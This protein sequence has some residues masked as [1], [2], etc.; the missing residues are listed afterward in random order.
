MNLKPACTLGLMLSTLLSGCSFRI[1]D[2]KAQ[3]LYPQLRAETNTQQQVPLHYVR[4]GDTTRPLLVYIHGS[5]GSWKDALHYMQ[6]ASLAEAFEL[7]AIDRPGFGYSGRWR[8]GYTL[9]QQVQL[10]L[11]L[12]RR[13]KG[14]RPL[15]LMGHSYGGPVAAALAAELG[16]EVQGVAQLAGALDPA[17]E[18]P[19]RWRKF[20]LGARWL[21][22]GA[23]PQSN[24]ELWWLKKELYDLQP[25][26]AHITC[27]VLLFHAHDDVL[28]P[29]ANVAYMQQHIPHTLLYAFEDGNH[30]LHVNQVPEISR[31]L[32]W[33]WARILS[34]KLSSP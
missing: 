27:P 29:Y 7:V 15:Y 11:P 26:L 4:L 12:I 23:L 17:Q 16:T 8:R 33:H 25:R 22:P 28:V 32:A 21:L 9:A 2:R 5:P 20:F 30:F 3:R 31:L 24:G 6:Q 34:P 18:K 14:N 19:E 10:L 13:L 1:S